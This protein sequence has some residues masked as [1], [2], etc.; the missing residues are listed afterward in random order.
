ME[1]GQEIAV[2]KAEFISDVAALVGDN[3]VEPLLKE[4]QERY[5]QYKL[6]ETQCAQRKQ[7][8]IAKLPEIEKALDIVKLL[9]EKQDAGAEVLA[10]YELADNVYAKAKLQS[11][12]S[13]NLWL[14]AKVMVEYPLE[15]AREVLETQLANCRTNIKTQSSNLDLLRDN[16]ITTEVRRRSSSSGSSGSSGSSSGSGA[17]STCPPGRA[18]HLKRGL[19]LQRQLRLRRLQPPCACEWCCMALVPARPL[20][21]N[22]PHFLSLLVAQVCMARV[23]N[24][25]VERRRK[26]KEAGK[27]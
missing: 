17:T 19:L 8:L 18:Q 27:E 3:P 12:A 22:C 4:L 13:V 14:G 20:R 24:Y 21:L 1:G 6:V 15:E 23:F 5:S 26:A 11:V 10:D 7:R 16:I 9:L 2:P 25:D